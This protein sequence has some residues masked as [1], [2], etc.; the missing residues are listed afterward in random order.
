MN[1]VIEGLHVGHW[2]VQVADFVPN[3]VDGARGW[4]ES[5][6]G[7]LFYSFSSIYFRFVSLAG[8][9]AENYGI[10]EDEF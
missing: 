5:G 7:F 9:K 6:Y 8:A 1:G 3:P 2:L 4:V 10:N